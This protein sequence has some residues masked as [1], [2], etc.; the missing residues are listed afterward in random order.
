MLRVLAQFIAMMM[1]MVMMVEKEEDETEEREIPFWLTVFKSNSL[2]GKNDIA[3]VF[4]QLILK[5][6]IFLFI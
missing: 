6:R 4:C 5:N 1:M 3:T 2:L